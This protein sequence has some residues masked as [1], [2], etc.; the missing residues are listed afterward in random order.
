MILGSG[1]RGNRF[2][3]NGADLKAVPVRMP[4]F[5]MLSIIRVDSRPFAASICFLS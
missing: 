3:G 5:E 1:D 2:R 4:A